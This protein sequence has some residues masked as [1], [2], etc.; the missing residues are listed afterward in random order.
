MAVDVAGAARRV[1]A[2]A[3]AEVL[4]VHGT[5]DRAVPP[6]DGRSLHAALCEGAAAAAGADAVGGERQRRAPR[7]VEVQGA[8]HNFRKEE[9]LVEALE[10][11]VGFFTT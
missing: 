10:E 1:G 9:H 11:I 4:V 3:R 6:E 2:S 5:A 8:D 7:L